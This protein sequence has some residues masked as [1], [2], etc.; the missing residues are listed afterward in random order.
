MKLGAGYWG[1]LVSATIL[2]VAVGILGGVVFGRKESTALEVGLTEGLVIAITG[3]TGG[4]FTYIFSRASVESAARGL[5]KTH[6]RPA[7]RR[8]LHLY[9]GL[10]RLGASI[11]ERR[12]ILTAEVDQQGGVQLAFVQS[13]LDLLYAEVVEQTATADDAMNDWR[14]LVPDEV[15]QIEAVAR[16]NHNGVRGTN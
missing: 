5:V 13:A 11:D 7:F 6:S 10:Q 3:V 2:L 15:A 8:V 14:D 1:L 12:R 4:L 9:A 16:G